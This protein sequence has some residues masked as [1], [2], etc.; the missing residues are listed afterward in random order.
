MHFEIR[1]HPG[2]DRLQELEELLAPMPTMTLANHLAG[3][4]I[5]RGEEE[6]RP[7]PPVVVGPALG[8]AKVIGKTGAVRSSAWI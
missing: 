3:R 6:R 5:K 4:D 1:R 2:L 7:V 8:R